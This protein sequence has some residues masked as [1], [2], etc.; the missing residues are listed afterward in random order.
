MQHLV[1]P[2]RASRPAGRTSTRSPGASASARRSR[3][4]CRRRISQLTN[5]GG[6]LPGG[7]ADDVELANAA[8][9]QG[10]V[11]ATPLQ[12]ALVAATVANDGEL[13]EPRLVTALVDAQGPRDGDRAAVDGPGARRVG[14]TRP[15]S[16]R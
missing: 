10:E 11:L 16:R 13:M 12:M 7:F 1:R 5:G 15:S 2:R 9:G 8:Y 14:T 3:S 6:P 4:T